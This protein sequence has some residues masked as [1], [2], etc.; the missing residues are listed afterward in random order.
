MNEPLPR[1]TLLLGTRSAGKLR[2]LRPIFGGAGVR[3]V[4][5]DEAGIEH[6]PDE[7]EIEVFGTFEENALAKARYYNRR[8]GL[9]VA[10]DD[11]G[12]A[13]DA[14]GGRPGVHSKRWSGRADLD[15]AALDAANN[16]AL[17]EALAG[18]KDWRARY[19]CVAALVGGGVERTWR[20]ETTGYIVSAARGTE[21]FGYDPHFVSDELEVTFGEAGLAAKARVSHRGR[22][23]AALIA[24]LGEAG[25]VGSVDLPHQVG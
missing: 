7:D 5:L 3:V 14:L 16:Q 18:V 22:A 23:F 21:G 11:S 20:G 10:A 25:L 13:V 2:E 9:P 1:G 24:G 4:G 8:S 17:L 19:V 6:S 15:G 12:L